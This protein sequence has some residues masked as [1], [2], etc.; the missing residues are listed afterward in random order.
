MTSSS[1]SQVGTRS[2]SGEASCAVSEEGSVMSLR[3]SVKRAE[4]MLDTFESCGKSSTLSPSCVLP[5]DECGGGVLSL[6]RDGNADEV[7]SSSED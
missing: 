1:V 7:D 5:G 3:S 4:D 6:L 2:L